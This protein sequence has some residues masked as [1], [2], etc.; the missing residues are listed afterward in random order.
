MK[1]F[2]YMR[3]SKNT[4]AQKHDRQELTLR[5]YAKANEFIIDEFIIESISGAINTDKREAY[6]NL[7]KVMR[8][9]D[10]L[11]LTDVERLG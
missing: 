3:K 9:D 8:R 7:K 10:V 4:D 5:E 6:S 1:I 2:A 11:L